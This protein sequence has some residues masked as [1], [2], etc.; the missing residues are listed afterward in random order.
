MQFVRRPRRHA[1]GPNDSMRLHESNTRRRTSAVTTVLR[2]QRAPC[3]PEEHAINGPLLLRAALAQP[4]ISFGKWRMPP[5]VFAGLQ[6]VGFKSMQRQRQQQPRRRR[7]QQL[8]SSMTSCGRRPT[9]CLR[10]S[11]VVRNTKR[12]TSRGSVVYG[13]RR[14]AASDSEI[15]YP[16][17]TRA[18]SGSVRARGRARRRRNS[19]RRYTG[20]KHFVR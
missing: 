13:R 8:T 12:P 17:R 3:I 20:V 10:R 16:R 6:S 18:L 15:H 14:R 4:G 2:S 1:R 11:H 7:W 19:G 9:L 5:H